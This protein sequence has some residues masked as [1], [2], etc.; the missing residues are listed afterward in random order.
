MI[1]YVQNNNLLTEK[2][3]IKN[4]INKLNDS[5]KNIGALNSFKELS[6]KINNLKSIEIAENDIVKITE[7]NK[8]VLE[9]EKQLNN[10][11]N[12][13]DSA[14]VVLEDETNLP[15]LEIIGKYTPEELEIFEK[16]R[17]Q[18]TITMVNEAEEKIKHRFYNIV[19]GK[20]ENDI[21]V[22]K[23]S[24]FDI[25]ISIIKDA[26]FYNRLT[27]DQI[28]KW[29]KRFI[30]LLIQ[31]P[32]EFLA[33]PINLLKDINP[34]YFYLLYD[35]IIKDR[36]FGFFSGD[37]DK[38]VTKFLNNQ[39]G[40][41]FLIDIINKTITY[42]KFARLD[43]YY[44]LY[45]NITSDGEKNLFESILFNDP[46]KYIIEDDIKYIKNEHLIFIPK[47]IFTSGGSKL[48]D[49][50]FVNNKKILKNLKKAHLI[51]V[52]KEFRALYYDENNYDNINY[53]VIKYFNANEIYKYIYSTYL[54]EN[55]GEPLLY[56]KGSHDKIT[57]LYMH[58]KTIYNLN[59]L[60]VFTDVYNTLF[61]KINSLSLAS[62][63]KKKSSGGYS[64][65][66][67]FS[68][69]IKKSTISSAKNSFYEYKTFFY[70]FIII[71]C[72]IIIYYLFYNDSDDSDDSD[73]LDETEDINDMSKLVDITC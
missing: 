18:K 63:I 45:S 40:M 16:E 61:D 31:N 22:S 46:S 6:E 57:S 27:S 69:N 71:T 14:E 19:G 17:E 2:E 28:K 21:D 15:S 13:L 66:N 64:I 36:T 67:N 25:Y 72:F 23:I 68:T 53:N 5:I 50:L 7:L 55:P 65:I 44:F 37:S 20:I 26:E 9:I 10:F 62:S 35:K 8:D 60:E 56:F 48:F 29:D 39:E 32:D 42:D 38:L 1:P 12:I 11:I 59:D 43:D 4:K 51:S 70:I 41:K 54:D 58:L 3:K 52:T 33:I 24:S 34:D 30:E 47:Y 49:L 73:D